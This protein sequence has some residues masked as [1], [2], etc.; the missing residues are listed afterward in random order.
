MLLVIKFDIL[1]N[2]EVTRIKVNVTRVTK[3]QN[4]ILSRK[5]TPFSVSFTNLVCMLLV[6]SYTSYQRSR[7]LCQRS[8]SQMSL[9]PR[10]HCVTGTHLVHKMKHNITLHYL[11]N[12]IPTTPKNSYQ[13]ITPMIHCRTQTYQLSFLPS[14][15]RDWKAL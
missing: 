2:F 1:S 5:C 7:S 4:Y 8:R 15:I 9:L 13:L 11:S 6:M 14:V 12:M 10:G 3:S